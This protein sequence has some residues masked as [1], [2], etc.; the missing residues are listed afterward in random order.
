MAD[1]EG[2]RVVGAGG[3][4]RHVDLGVGQVLSM[5]R[6]MVCDGQATVCVAVGNNQQQDEFTSLFSKMGRDLVYQKVTLRVML[7]QK[8]S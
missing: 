6:I 4:P 3:E 7:T 2:G 5:T 1:L 8:G